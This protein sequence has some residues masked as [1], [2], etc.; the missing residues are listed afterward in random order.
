MPEPA[1]TIAEIEQ[2][3]KALAA[4]IR[5]IHPEHRLVRRAEALTHLETARALAVRAAA[6]GDT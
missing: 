3:A 1:P 6:Q 5:R 2:A 4:I